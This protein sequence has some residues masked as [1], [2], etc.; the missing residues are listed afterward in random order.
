MDA[1]EFADHVAQE[2]VGAGE[3][4]QRRVNNYLKLQSEQERNSASL[5]ERREKDRKLGQFYKSVI[6]G[7]KKRRRGN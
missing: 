3:L 6:A 5:A 4:D 1:S 7:K 2:V